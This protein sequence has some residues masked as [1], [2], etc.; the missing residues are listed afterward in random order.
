MKKLTDIIN[1]NTNV[2]DNNKILVEYNV[3]QGELE[4]IVTKCFEYVSQLTGHLSDDECN[5]VVDKLI[6][7]L[8]NLKGE[9]TDRPGNDDVVEL[10][11]GYG[12]DNLQQ[13]G[14]QL[15]QILKDKSELQEGTHYCIVD[16][17]LNEWNSGYRY[18]GYNDFN[19]IDFHQFKNTLDIHDLGEPDMYSDEEVLDMI[20]KGQIAFEG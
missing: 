4:N 5:Y 15:G 1:E 18:L 17:G 16:L 19:G 7:D 9:N 3:P 6:E 14:A 10:E 11:R 8:N 2:K 12:M 20:Q 13:Q